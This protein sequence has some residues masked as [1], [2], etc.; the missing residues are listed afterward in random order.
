MS[1]R[2]KWGRRRRRP[3]PWKLFA[4]P[5][6][7]LHDG[8]PPPR[9]KAELRALAEKAA[10][11]CPVTRLPTMMPLRCTC[12]HR[13][14]VPIAPDVKSRRFRCLRCGKRHGAQALANP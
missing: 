5:N 7:H 2:R 12:G 9:P 13:A 14:T 6:D 11:D 1:R 3:E 8:D 4:D 10:R